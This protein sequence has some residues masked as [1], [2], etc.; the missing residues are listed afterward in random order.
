ME[1]IQNINNEE[2]NLQIQEIK[3][4]DNKDEDE[5]YFNI[6]KSSLSEISKK[7]EEDLDNSI[8]S[9]HQDKFKISG[10][11]SMLSFPEGITKGISF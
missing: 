7:N 10:T 6:N 3:N 1:Q 2:N 4:S 9:K 11:T 8:L 5:S